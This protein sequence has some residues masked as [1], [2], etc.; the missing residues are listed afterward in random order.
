MV[1]SG[2]C[3][4]EVFS[5]LL[6][7]AGDSRE[8]HLTV[9]E[10][11]LGTICLF[12]DLA[13][14]PR[15]ALVRV[16]ANARGRLGPFHRQLLG[17]SIARRPGAGFAPVLAPPPAR[18]RPWSSTHPSVRLS[19]R[20]AAII[21]FDVGLGGGGI[22]LPVFILGLP[23]ALLVLLPLQDPDRECE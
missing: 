12:E 17:A 20:P 7:A 18:P 22:P 15:I 5:I 21:S 6:P 4:Y 3:E 13:H 23:G 9:K 16:H 1:R 2:F 14:S 19:V 11:H 8:R 10:H